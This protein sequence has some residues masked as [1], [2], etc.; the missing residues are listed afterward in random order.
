MLRCGW[1]WDNKKMSSSEGDDLDLS[2]E[3][4]L[5]GRV[6]SF[7]RFA[8]EQLSD[9]KKTHKSL[10]ESLNNT[11]MISDMAA[12]KAELSALKSRVADQDQKIE[13]LRKQLEEKG[14]SA[15]AHSG[16]QKR[17]ASSPDWTPERKQRRSEELDKILE[18]IW[19]EKS[20]ARE[21]LTER[22]QA[23]FSYMTDQLKIKDRRNL[24]MNVATVLNEGVF[25]GVWEEEWTPAG[26]KA[27]FKQYLV[28]KIRNHVKKLLKRT[29]EKS[30]D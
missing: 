11:T 1:K 5:V 10:Q 25:R 22:Q 24:E 8:I 26:I 29:S 28:E 27:T 3:E 14:S 20:D 17:P 21:K 7:K 13:E 23:F 2:F 4:V 15:P 30:T 6:N 12:V 18:P 9:V 16:G 19:P